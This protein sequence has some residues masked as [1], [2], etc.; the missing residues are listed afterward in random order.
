MKEITGNT[1]LFGIIADPIYHVKTPQRMNEHFA[2]IGFDGV[3]VPFHVR[4]EGL[5]AALAGF[6]TMP[7][8]GGIIVTMPHK[9]AV[10]DLVDEVSPVAR[11]IGA[12]N[13]IRR[14]AD[15]S[16]YAHMLDGEG[17][18][19]GLHEAQIPVQGKTA[20][21]AG[22]GGAAN[23]IGFA[24]VQAGVSVLTI[25]NRTQAKAQDLKERILSLHPQADI[26]I[27]TDDPSGHDL[28]VNGTSLGMK[29][30]DALPLDVSKLTPAQYVCE[31]IMEPKITPLLQAALDKGCPV[32]YGA[33]MLACQIQLMAQMLG[34][35]VE[36]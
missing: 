2:R 11:K 10:L 12:A 28:V 16:L 1:R 30:T 25:A 15:G 21:L 31:V 4:P 24:L 36:S 5:A 29:A 6:R 22:A 9:S 26:R 3:C 17:F 27:G 14:N 18:V 20:Y 32:Q 19:R 33:P 8:L 23:A 13:V 35:E 34:V 7:N